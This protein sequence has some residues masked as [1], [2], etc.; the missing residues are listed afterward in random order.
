MMGDRIPCVPKRNHLAR[1]LLGPIGVCHYVERAT[2]FSV[3][4][5]VTDDQAVN[6]AQITD[7]FLKNAWGISHSAGS[8][9]WV[10]DNGT[11]VSTLYSVN[12]TTNAT[13]KVILGSPPDPSGGVVIPPPGSGT[14]T[15]QVFNTASATAFN[16]DLFLFVSEDGTISG[17]RSALGTTAERLQLPDPANV[18]K[19][20]TLDT[21]G[22]HSYLLSANFR[23]GTIDVL[24]GD[25]GTPDL[26]GKFT[27]PGT[28]SSFAPFQHPGP[29]EQDLRDLRPCKMPRKHDD[30]A[31]AGNGFVTAFDLQGNFLGRIG[32]MGTLN[33]PWG[34]AIAPSSFRASPATCWSATSATERSTSSTPTRRHPVSWGS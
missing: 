28:P 24:K 1:S 6:S 5:L 23:T 19:G 32:S 21:T 34:L 26:A 13:T 3:T 8:P 20:T 29:R 17:W 12:P 14:P 7:T 30:V 4:N 25:N 27:D 11:G 22:G 10:S 15:G 16:N 18:Y 2:S 9:F 31:G 33:S